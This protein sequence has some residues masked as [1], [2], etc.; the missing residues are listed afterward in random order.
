MAKSQQE[1][2]ALMNSSLGFESTNKSE[3][4]TL[5]DDDGEIDLNFFNGLNGF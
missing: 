3:M 1:T 5:I 4:T 2:Y